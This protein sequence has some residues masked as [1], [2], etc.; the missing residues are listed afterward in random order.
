MSPAN[1]LRFTILTV[2]EPY[3]VSSIYMRSNCERFFSLS[4]CFRIHTDLDVHTHTRTYTHI[5][6]HKH[7]HRQ[8]V[9]NT[10]THTLTRTRARAHTHTRE[11]DDQN[12]EN[13]VSLSDLKFSANFTGAKRRKLSFV[14]SYSYS[15]FPGKFQRRQET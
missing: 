14:F 8:I 12:P 10:H 13:H 2:F 3:F 15:F 6:T 4:F 1:G 9:E 5:H 7:S 11:R